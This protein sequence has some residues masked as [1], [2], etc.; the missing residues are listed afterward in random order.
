M[1]I[2]KQ[3]FTFTIVLYFILLTISS[4]GYCAQTLEVKD[5]EVN[6]EG[7]LEGVEKMLGSHEQDIALLESDLNSLKE[8]LEKLSIVEKKLI[9]GK[10]D[11]EA[12]GLI[13]KEEDILGN[14]INAISESIRARSETTEVA[15]NLKKAL[16]EK[17][18]LSEMQNRVDKDAL[19]LPVSQLESVQKESVLLE[20]RL[21]SI[22][23]MSRDREIDYLTMQS[24][25]DA[26]RLGLVGEKKQLQNEARKLTR[27]K[28]ETHE[29]GTLIDSKKRIL[30]SELKLRDDKIK[31]LLMQTE[32]AKLRSQSAQ[33]QRSNVELERD[34]KTEI[35]N[36][37]SLKFKGAEIEREKKAAEEAKKAEGERRRIAE[38][39]RA[40]VEL[41]KKKA[42]KKEGIAVQKQLEETS[43][44]KKKILEVEA[45]VY[46][47]KRLVAIKK[48]ELIAVGTEKGEY[49]A[50][51]SQIQEDIKKFIEDENT[52][53][54]ITAKLVVI[55]AESKRIQN[56]VKN[57]QNRLSAVEKQKVIIGESLEQVRLDLIP[58]V[59][60]EKSNIEKEAEKF[61]SIEQG[62][63]LV[64]LANLRLKHIEEQKNLIEKEFEIGNV[65]LES[66]TVFL[67]KLADA[68]ERL[69]DILAANVWERRESGI[70]TNTV[71][72]GLSDIKIL[73]DKPVD[74]YKA[75]V[76]YLKKLSVYLSKTENIPDFIIK[77]IIVVFV[78]IFTFFARRFLNKWAD[79][80]IE[81]YTASIS[82]DIS[83]F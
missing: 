23:A 49:L 5:A 15:N 53:G 22:L 43:P 24:K 73:K 8:V 28:P 13:T 18:S 47:Q 7:L 26:A 4:V 21:E 11:D 17:S 57:I 76:H 67:G 48:E 12:L 72:E 60:G 30:E 38:E 66:S 65:L 61:S 56:K 20:A 54:E 55:D 32:L 27:L 71:I 81:R 9:E 29:G 37:L 33:V 79:R 78:I 82:T 42:L 75:F 39:E 45:D 59:Q 31:L 40:A 2:K 50:E 6:Q 10:G 58:A 44:E 16:E 62:K 34:I 64:K 69:S 77:V 68:K 3:L 63:L 51:L 52:P 41:E 83:H 19:L 36:I 1:I 74:F 25:N 46:K 70:S 80:E 14:R 35:A